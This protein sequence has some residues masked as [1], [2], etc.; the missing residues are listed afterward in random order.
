M[1][2]SEIEKRKRGRPKVADPTKSKRA[3]V[4]RY[5]QRERER[6]AYM[7]QVTEAAER[8][9]RALNENSSSQLVLPLDLV[10]CNTPQTLYNIAAFVEAE[11]AREIGRQKRKTKGR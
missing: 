7:T 6:K 2:I 11:N 8:L 9:Q 4:R 10:A 1:L 5:Q 3:A